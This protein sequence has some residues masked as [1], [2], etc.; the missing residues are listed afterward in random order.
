MSL[1]ERPFF[2]ESDALLLGCHVLL[3]LETG[4][5][6]MHAADYQEIAAWLTDMV[7]GMATP[8]VMRL[9]NE[10]P[11]ALRDVA[12]NALCARGEPEWARPSQPG[13]TPPRP[14]VT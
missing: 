6:R 4:R 11:P 2:A 9:R 8:V 12:E 1:R 3:A 13:I 10:G 7:A 14:G 5:M